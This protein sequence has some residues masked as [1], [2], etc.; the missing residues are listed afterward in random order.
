M[1]DVESRPP[2]IECSGAEGSGIGYVEG[3]TCNARSAQATQKWDNGIRDTQIL[4]GTTRSAGMIK[5]WNNGI[6]D[7]HKHTQALQKVSDIVYH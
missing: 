3:Y 6:A 7:A 1:K 5:R 4:T 2:S